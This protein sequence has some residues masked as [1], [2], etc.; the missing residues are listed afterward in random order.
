MIPDSLH[1]VAVDFETQALPKRL[2]DAGLDANLPT[3]FAMLGVVMYL[4]RDAFGETLKYIAAFPE[5]SGVVFDYAVPRDMLPAE[6]LD[7]RDELASRV[8]SIGEPFRLFFSPDEV[9]DV[10]RAFERIEDVDDEELNQL[11]FADR[12]DQLNL[13]GRSGHMIAAFRGSSLVL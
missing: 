9:K 12:T 4:T 2:K 10:L 11:Y 3:V 7:A 5:K 6:E 13:K 8:E 1:F